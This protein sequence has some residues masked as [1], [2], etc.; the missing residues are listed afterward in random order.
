MYAN[1]II[2]L[3]L[4][5]LRDELDNDRAVTPTEEQSF[6]TETKL[7]ILRRTTSVN[8]KTSATINDVN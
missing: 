7:Y 2:S 6:L 4:I 8:T 3:V 1:T 5:R